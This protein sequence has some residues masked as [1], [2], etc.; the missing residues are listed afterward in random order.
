[1]DNPKDTLHVIYQLTCLSD[2]SQFFFTTYNS[3]INSSQTLATK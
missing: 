3:A 1:M 2:H